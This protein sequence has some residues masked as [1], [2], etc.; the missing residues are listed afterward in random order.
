[1][2]YLI[3]DEEVEAEDILIL[4]RGDHNGTFSRPIKAALDD[5]GIQYSDPDVVDQMLAEPANRRMLATFRLLVN[6]SDSL[7]WASLL[8]LAHGIGNAFLDYIY[9]SARSA[10]TVRCGPAPG[11]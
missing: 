2:Q 11:V 8:V 10:G 1:M 9:E 6:R 5:R 3:D 7:A 4:L